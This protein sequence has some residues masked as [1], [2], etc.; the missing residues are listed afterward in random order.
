MNKEIEWT[1]NFV[2]EV[3]NKKNTHVIK[4]LMD[5]N[6]LLHSPLGDFHS[7]QAMFEVVNTW[8]TAFPDMAVKTLHVT[9]QENVVMWHWQSEQTHTGE[10]QG[11]AASGKRVLYSGVSIFRWENGKIVEYW[12]YPQTEDLLRQLGVELNATSCV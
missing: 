3:W 4:D 7:P 1:K 10:F 8:L 11:I 12:G 5:E 2:N 6:V 9:N